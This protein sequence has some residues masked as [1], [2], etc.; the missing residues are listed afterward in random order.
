LSSALLGTAR[1]VEYS[2]DVRA[3]GAYMSAAQ[4]NAAAL[5][6]RVPEGL[7]MSTLAARLGVTKQAVTALVARMEY[8]DLALRTEHSLDGRCKLVRLTEH[9][10]SELVGV[11]R[12]LGALNRELELGLGSERVAQLK[13]ALRVIA[14]RA[15]GQQP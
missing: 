5:L 10:A 8:A 14:A 2:C 9:G 4:A 6:A 3:S 12:R 13:D 11:A 1:G 15:P 7:P